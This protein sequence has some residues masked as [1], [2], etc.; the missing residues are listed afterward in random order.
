M[1]DNII[2]LNVRLGPTQKARI[3]AAAKALRVSVQSLMR[4]GAMRLV[5]EIESIPDA[6]GRLGAAVRIDADGGEK[7]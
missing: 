7:V 3:D 5:S 2:Q 1:E 4:A 6:A